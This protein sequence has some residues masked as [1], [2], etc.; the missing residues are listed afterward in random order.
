MCSLL[1]AHAK[2]W[3]SFQLSHGENNKAMSKT[4][5]LAAL[6]QTRKQV[7]AWLSSCFLRSI[8]RC[9]QV[10]DLGVCLCSRMPFSTH[11]STLI[12]S[13]SMAQFVGTNTG[14]QALNLASMILSFPLQL[15]S[16]SCISRAVPR[17]LRTSLLTLTWS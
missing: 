15:M 8:A 3:P 9:L 13:V 4:E 16:L 10:C 6:I 14:L 5:H 17:Q 7:S 11:H 12:R 2:Q 1:F